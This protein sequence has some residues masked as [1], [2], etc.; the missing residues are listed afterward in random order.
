M[1]KSFFF[2]ILGNYFP[3]PGNYSMLGGVAAR[4]VLSNMPNM[5]GT[6]MPKSLRFK[7]TNDTKEHPGCYYN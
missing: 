5:Q 7:D 1:V 3:G 4:Q 6:K 2:V